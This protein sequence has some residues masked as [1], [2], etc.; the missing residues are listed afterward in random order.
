MPSALV[1]AFNRL[2]GSRIRQRDIVVRLL[3]EASDHPTVTQLH[4]RARLEAPGISRSSVYT[5][6]K[7]LVATSLARAYRP[8]TG[9]YRYE[10]G[11]LPP[12]AH[13]VD[14]ASGEMFNIDDNALQQLLQKTARKLGYDLTDF[15]MVITG[16]RS[17]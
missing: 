8:D 4:A 16:S 3:A 17:P 14:E 1:A 2:A 11:T 9:E 12:H 15:E 5:T 13:L 10:D 6:L 7:L